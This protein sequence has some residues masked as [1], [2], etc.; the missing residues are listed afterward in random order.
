MDTVEDGP[1]LGRFWAAVV[2]GELRTTSDDPT[3]DV[4]VPGVEGGGIAM[5]PVPEQKTVKHR[6]MAETH[7]ATSL[8]PAGRATH[9]KS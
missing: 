9:R 7:D 3:G 1:R 2:G 5:C 6:R 4:V 8:K